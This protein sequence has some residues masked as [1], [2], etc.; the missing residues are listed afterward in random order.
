MVILLDPW[1]SSVTVTLEKI[2]GILAACSNT[3]FGK[4]TTWQQKSVGGVVCFFLGGGST[5]YWGKT[6][7]WDVESR[8][9][10]TADAQYPQLYR[11]LFVSETC[12]RARTP[13]KKFLFHKWKKRQ[14][15]LSQ[16]NPSPSL[17]S[18]SA[19]FTQLKL[20]MIYLQLHA[21]AVWHMLLPITRQVEGKENR[22]CI[23]LKKVLRLSFLEKT[24]F[25]YTHT[26]RME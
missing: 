2:L 5:S 20:Q 19:I 23:K 13:K 24:I 21:A 25:L 22:T 9:K 17:T 12:A 26:P 14:H 4:Q 18:P 11:L 6:R 10:H 15:F 3:I 1:T 7:Y 16:N 8:H